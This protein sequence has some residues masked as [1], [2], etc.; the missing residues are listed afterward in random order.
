MYVKLLTISKKRIVARF[1]PLFSTQRT[2]REQ[3][4]CHG[5]PECRAG[6]ADLFSQGQAAV[7]VQAIVDAGV[8]AILGGRSLPESND[9]YLAEH[10]GGSLRARAAAAEMA[11]L[12]EPGGRAHA[13]ALLLGGGG[14]VGA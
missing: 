1:W 4:P 8:S 14:P 7:E 12:L 6:L 5:H 11:A 3:P 13:A 2:E 9:A 10:G